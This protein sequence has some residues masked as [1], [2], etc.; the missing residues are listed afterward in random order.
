MNHICIITGATG[1]IGSHLLKYLLSKGWDVYIIVQPEFGYSNIEDVIDQIDVFEYNQNIG[2]LVDYFKFVNAEVVFHLASA[3]ITNYKP[4]QVPV[5]IQSNIQF[6]TEIL[7]AMKYS[8]TRLF[9]GTGSNWQN[10]NDDV[11]NP[12]DLYAA[13]KEAFEKVLKFYVDAHHFRAISLRLFD[14]YGEDDNRPQAV[15]SS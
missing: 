11:Y 15:E 5:L 13:T 4:E 14:I 2:K 12:V 9:V 8:S 10:Y 3:V 6:G 7:E 1:Y